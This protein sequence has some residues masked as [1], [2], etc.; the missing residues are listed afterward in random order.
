MFP[1]M[2][3]TIHPGVEP[4]VDQLPVDRPAQPRHLSCRLDVPPDQHQSGIL[5][6]HSTQWPHQHPGPERFQPRNRKQ[7]AVVVIIC[8]GRIRCFPTE[9]PGTSSAGRDPASV[10]HN[11]TSVG[12]EY[13]NR[14][15][16]ALLPV[17]TAPGFVPGFTR[18]DT[19]IVWLSH[20]T[21]VWRARCLFVRAHRA[22]YCCSSRCR[23]GLRLCFLQA[24]LCQF[25]P[26]QYRQ[27]SVDSFLSLVLVADGAPV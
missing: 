5:H 9:S 17:G 8:A 3:S 7:C 23:S 10:G 20:R 16:P 22:G 6:A 14:K 25:G 24:V 27:Q 11:P 2:A 4:L 26:V 18:S 15:P 19:G 1:G 21:R 12:R 13:H